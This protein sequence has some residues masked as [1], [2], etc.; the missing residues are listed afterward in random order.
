MSTKVDLTRS[1]M[2]SVRSCYFTATFPFASLPLPGLESTT[3]AN[4]G[5]SRLSPVPR[6]RFPPGF[7]GFPPTHFQFPPLRKERAKIGH[8]LWRWCRQASH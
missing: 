3:S 8:A 6:P 7:P 1:G 2:C 5:T 4:W